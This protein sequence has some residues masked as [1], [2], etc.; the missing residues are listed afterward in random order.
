MVFDLQKLF[1]PSYLFTRSPEVLSQPFRIAWLSLSLGL[2]ACGVG[3]KLWVW[4]RHD[5]TPAWGQWWRRLGTVAVVAGFVALILLFFRYE[6]APIL[7]SRYW[8]V[9]WGFVLLSVVGRRL[10]E[11]KEKVPAAVAEYER[12]RRLA[13]YLPRS[14]G[15]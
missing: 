14:G 12:Q 1:T 11:L 6:Q 5:L 7:S 15:S 3:V 8:M 10:W 13:K 2:V 4:W 9:L